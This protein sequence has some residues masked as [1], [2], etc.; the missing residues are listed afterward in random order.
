M[1]PGKETVGF[2]VLTEQTATSDDP[3]EQQ[4]LT[5]LMRDTMWEIVTTVYNALP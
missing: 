5:I 3:A 1:P 4:K 2:A